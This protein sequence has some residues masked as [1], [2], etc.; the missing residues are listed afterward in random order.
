MRVIAWSHRHCYE[1]LE[2]NSD[3]MIR[4]THHDDTEDSITS[5][6]FACEEHAGSYEK[7]E[8]EALLYSLTIASGL[9]QTT[10]NKVW[11]GRLIKT[12]LKLRSAS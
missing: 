12:I 3:A 11:A 7:V 5:W 10:E 4:C 8:H 6:R 1:P 2:M 9:C